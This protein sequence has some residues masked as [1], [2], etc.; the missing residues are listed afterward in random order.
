MLS[1]ALGL[2]GGMVA[3]WAL[4]LQGRFSIPAIIAWGSLYAIFPLWVGF[5]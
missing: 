3:Y 4:R 2:A 1:A 5:A